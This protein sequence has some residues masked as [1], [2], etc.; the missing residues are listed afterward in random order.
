MQLPRILF[1]PTRDPR[2]PPAP[3]TLLGAREPMQ[4]PDKVQPIRL[5]SSHTP[6][7]F[8]AR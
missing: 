7:D 4:H 6:I 5:R 1:I 3:I 8:K 2:D